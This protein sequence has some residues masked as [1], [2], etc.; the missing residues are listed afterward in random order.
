[1]PQVRL[2][3]FDWDGT[4]M[5]SE[6]AIVAAMDLAYRE[7]DVTPPPYG[8]IRD[9]I[10]LSLVEAVQRLTPKLHE[11]VVN[12][13]VGNYRNNFAARREQPALFP[14]VRDTLQGL[15][16][17]GYWLA[18]ATGKSRA[19]L[20]RAI[21]ESAMGELFVSTRTAEQTEPKPSPAML[22]EILTDLALAPHDALV[23]GDTEFD[24]AMARAAG[25]QAAGVSYGA[26]AVERLLEYDPAFVLNHFSELPEKLKAFSTTSAT[27]RSSN[28][29]R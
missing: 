7:A 21:E 13:V 3:I 18:V 1:M 23:I 19:G 20:A 26:H 28:S 25:T 2:I 5:D 14:G 8:E 29:I 4:L 24:L 15:H 11:T 22:H 6:A 16:R 27:P 17:S 12:Q 10:G 9:I